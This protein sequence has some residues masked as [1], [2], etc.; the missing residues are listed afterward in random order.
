MARVSSNGW[1]I[2]TS[3]AGTAQ[4]VVIGEGGAHDVVNV[5]AAKVFG[6]L[7]Y[8]LGTEAWAKTGGVVSCSGGRTPAQQAQ[9]N[10]GVYFSC[11]LSFSACD[12]SD[13][14]YHPYEP[15]LNGAAYYSG[16]TKAEEQQIDAILASPEFAG[17]LQWGHHFPAPYRDPVH[18]QLVQDLEY[19]EAGPQ[20][21]TPAMLRRAAKA[22]DALVRR[23]QTS[24]GAK[25]DGYAGPGTLAA[26]KAWQASRGLV[27]DGIFGRASQAAAGWGSG[28]P[29][30]AARSHGNDVSNHQTVAQ[31]QALKPQFLIAKSSEGLSWRD[32]AYPAH[33]DG[34]RSQ[35]LPFGAYIYVWPE[36]DPVA[37]CTNF[38]AISGLKAGEWGVIDFEPYSSKSDP[39]TWPAWVVTFALE[40]RRQRGEWPWLYLNDDMAGRLLARATPTQAGV[41][42][43]LPLW[44][45]AYAR[46]PGSLHGWPRLTAWQY[47]G[48]GVDANWRY[49]AAH[50]TPTRPA[51]G[52]SH[53]TARPSEGG[54]DMPD[55]AKH[56]DWHGNRELHAGE[57][58]LAPIDR[59]AAGN[60]Y[61]V[62]AGPAAVLC[63]A[64]F[65]VEG[66]PA[67]QTVQ[68]RGRVYERRDGKW[69][70]SRS[71]GAR[72]ATTT[73]GSAFVG[74]TAVAPNLGHGRRLRFEV[75][76]P[77]DATLTRVTTDTL[78]WKD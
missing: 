37:A 11:H 72:E 6:W 38:L 60:L 34:A 61:S 28:K 17:V 78:L 65:A 29:K 42:R 25:P 13:N 52:H 64:S 49:S 20:V 46:T 30:P 39:A 31:W 4:F 63:N 50:P 76:A 51:A 21:V 33:R 14:R 27:V 47:S 54:P 70:P 77:A 62:A 57:W 19:L 7:F 36:Y 41:L 67:G 48:T 44:K 40:Y 68:V 69:H 59:H 8:R 74:V 45:A 71:L 66:L 26:V 2:L 10:P 5:D 43:S 73:T 24:V 35:R 58:R 15:R 75:L 1:P 3:Y 12:G 32:P 16:Y 23:I 56:Q 53:H 9:T 18:F 55:T 22:V